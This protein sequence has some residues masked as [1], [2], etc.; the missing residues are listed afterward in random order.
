MWE[1]KSSL[2]WPENRSRL[3]LCVYDTSMP[4]TPWQAPWNNAS[5]PVQRFIEWILIDGFVEHAEQNPDISRNVIKSP[6][7]KFR[8]QKEDRPEQRKMWSP[9]VKLH[10]SKF[11]ATVPCICDS[12]Y[13][14]FSIIE[15]LVIINPFFCTFHLN[16]SRKVK[17]LNLKN[18]HIILRSLC[19]LLFCAFTFSKPWDRADIVMLQMNPP[20]FDR[21]TFSALVLFSWKPLASMNKNAP[22]PSHCSTVLAPGQNPVHLGWDKHLGIPLSL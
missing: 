7:T 18:G 16:A 12:T 13:S 4:T 14:A 22:H 8:T 11:W 6:R 3:G 21:S 9:T 5:G 10:L 2:F 17:R 20:V 19:E 1:R 15:L